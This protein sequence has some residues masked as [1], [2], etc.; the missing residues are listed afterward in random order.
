MHDI[1]CDR[2][3]TTK[4]SRIDDNAF[5][6]L[7]FAH[8]LLLYRNW[9]HGFTLNR[10]EIEMRSGRYNCEH[11]TWISNTELFDTMKLMSISRRNS[12]EI[13]WNL[14]IYKIESIRKFDIHK[15]RSSMKWA[16]S[17]A[18]KFPQIQTHTSWARG[19]KKSLKTGQ[20][21]LFVV[22]FMSFFRYLFSRLADVYF[23]FEIFDL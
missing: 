14:F 5:K 17:L 12:H 16:A 11:G 19:E 9:K 2:E 21:L 1:V 18:F 8:F 6:Y 22:L 4:N 20:Y 10:R 7:A 15:N 23:I 13:T 3:K